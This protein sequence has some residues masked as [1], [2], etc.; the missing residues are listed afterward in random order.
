MKGWIM[1]NKIKTLKEQNL[2]VLLNILELKV[3]EKS[4][5]RL[6]SFILQFLFSCGQSLYSKSKNEVYY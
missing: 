3:R 6:F 4:L 2:K 5:K 1:F